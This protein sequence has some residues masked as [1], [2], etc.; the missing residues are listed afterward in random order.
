MGISLLLLY[1]AVFDAISFNKADTPNFVAASETLFHLDHE[2]ADT[3][4]RITKPVYLLFPGLLHVAMDVPITWGMR[5]QN[6]FMFLAL[7]YFLVQTLAVLHFDLKEQLLG[8]WIYLSYQVFAYTSTM[9]I[10]DI[11]GHF[12][13]FCTLYLYFKSPFCSWKKSWSLAWVLSLGLLSKESAGVALIPILIDTLIKNRKKVY[14]HN[15]V[16]VTLV[17]FIV[18]GVQFFLKYYY[19][20]ATVW[21]NVG[22]EFEINKGF[23][24]SWM[25]IWHTYDMQ[26]CFIGIGAYTLW[27]K[28]N[29]PE[30]RVWQYSFL[31]S[32]PFMFLW[33]TVQDRTVFSIA[34]V[35]SIVLL[36]GLRTFKTS[37]LQW[38]LPVLFGVLNVLVVALIYHFSIQNLL[39]AYYLLGMVLMI[40][41]YRKEGR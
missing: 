10:S 25:Q 40:I 16:M 30:L 9:L 6:G 19:G 2:L 8:L 41:A 1:T 5:V 31:L 34:P 3:Q 27:R 24:G 32:L 22:E 14:L 4:S 28:K 21:E 17:G 20:T 18:I 39:P 35:L 29:T 13:A 26:W 11:A 36:L 23:Q 37:W 15:G 7:I 38:R 12:F 33:A